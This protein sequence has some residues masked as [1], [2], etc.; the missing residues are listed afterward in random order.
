M[1]LVGSRHQSSLRILPLLLVAAVAGATVDDE[2]A[3]IVAKL[4]RSATLRDSV[5]AQLQSSD[6]GAL[7]LDIFRRQLA[8]GS[9]NGTD[10]GSKTS[11]SDG[12]SVQECHHSIF[13]LTCDPAQVG[14][15]VHCAYWDRTIFG[16]VLFGLVMLTL[17]IEF[18]LEH[19][20]KHT[21]KGLAA[22]LREKVL[23]ECTLLGL[24]SFF[25]IIFLHSG[26]YTSIDYL[27]NNEY[28]FLLFEFGHI[29]LFLTALA[30]SSC[31]FCL[32][33]I[34]RSIERY[35]GQLSTRSVDD[36]LRELEE[37]N[38]M[39]LDERRST[40]YLPRLSKY[41]GFSRMI[42]GALDGA[43]WLTPKCCA[44]WRAALAA[45]AVTL[46][47]LR[48]AV[49]MGEHRVLEYHF[50][51]EHR[52]QHIKNFSFVEYLRGALQMHVIQVGETRPAL[53]HALAARSS[54]GR[55]H[56][57]TCFLHTP[58]VHRSSRSSGRR[59]W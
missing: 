10:D 54:F 44:R 30:H 21:E 34:V 16:M 38:A 41:G 57:Y 45:R 15:G 27:K 1:Q 36:V 32:S 40:R 50:K 4:Q 8:G 18:V 58:Y 25:T 31:I 29:L 9:T 37:L 52:L 7:S 43:L 6:S 5:L 3:A 51:R 23:N 11:G 49:E 28:I 56:S 46:R 2:A 12:S 19:I 55:V 26:L 53:L 22:V 39:R 33:L 42:Q 17:L 20:E 47:R 13:A 14:T 59:G 24:V 48:E 35:W